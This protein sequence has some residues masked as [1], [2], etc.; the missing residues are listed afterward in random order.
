MKQRQAL[1][2]LPVALIR[3]NVLVFLTA[4]LTLFL[5]AVGNFQNFLDSTQFLL[6]RLLEVASLLCVLFGSY[7]FITH[8]WMRRRRKKI[9]RLGIVFSIAS[10]VVGAGLFA[11]VS[12][13]AAWIS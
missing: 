2:W 5:F 8:L 7:S 1:Y 13:I 6:L 4:L 12:F 11:G 10:V 3:I 9:R